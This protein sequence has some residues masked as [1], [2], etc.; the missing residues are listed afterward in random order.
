[1]ELLRRLVEESVGDCS[2]ELWTTFSTSG[3][4]TSH[5]EV[6]ARELP[7]FIYGRQGDRSLLES[8]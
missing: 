6:C 8:I 3:I 5:V 7:S 2:I 4:S 1:M